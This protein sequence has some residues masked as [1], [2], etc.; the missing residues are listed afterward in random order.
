MFLNRI[1][2]GGDAVRFLVPADGTWK[3]MTYREVGAAVRE[4]AHG[5]MAFGLAKGEKVAILSSTRVEWALADIAAILGGFVTVPIY[6]SNLPDQVEF[7]LAH[8]EARAVFVEHAMQWNK[9]AGSRAKLPA[10]A[11]VVLMTGDA[12]GKAGTIGLAD[13]RKAGAAHAAAGP[14][15]IVRRTEEILPD[16]DLTIIYTSGTTGPPKGVVTRHRNYAF[17][18]TSALEAVTIAKGAVF[19]QFLPLAHS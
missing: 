15:A 9:V 2:E 3:P 5:L 18:V 6:P 8:S 1:E 17:I 19:L 12:A 10:L 11:T 4:L 7:I 14:D 13:L 16:D